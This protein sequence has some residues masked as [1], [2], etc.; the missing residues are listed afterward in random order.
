VFGPADAEPEDEFR[1]LREILLAEMEKPDGLILEEEL[2]SG[3]TVTEPTPANENE[4]QGENLVSSWPRHTN[5]LFYK[6]AY[7]TYFLGR[8]RE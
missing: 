5:I 7:S 2:Q 6:G 3:G 4:A 8:R 1:T